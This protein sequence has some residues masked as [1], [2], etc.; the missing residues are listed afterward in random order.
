M[1]KSIILV[2]FLLLPISPVWAQAGFEDSDGKSSLI[3]KQGG[4][5]RI[6]LTDA[7]IKVGYVYQQSTEPFRLGVELSG[8]AT[9]GISTLFEKDDIAPEAK[10]KLSL[11]WQWLLSTKPS[12]GEESS[13]VVDDWA[14]FQLGYSRAQYKLFDPTNPFAGQIQNRN[15]NGFSF[16][17]YYNVLFRSNISIGVSLG[18]D[19]QNN[20]TD[21]KEVELFDRVTIYD[22]VGVFRA[23]TKT[24]KMRQGDFVETNHT[25]GNYDIVWVPEFLGNRIG[26]DLFGRFD[27]NNDENMF[28]PGVGVFIAEKGAPT[29]VVGAISFESIEGRLRI[30]LLVGF[31]F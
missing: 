24:E 7:S 9:N 30:G 13:L 21:L 22:S 3:L 16:A 26:F 19:H 11:G 18:L 1:L 31:N 6:N 23:T 29:K 15:F 5:G 20:Y 27:R 14:T 25:L 28:K 10:A 8:K 4:T 12:A 17:M 2:A